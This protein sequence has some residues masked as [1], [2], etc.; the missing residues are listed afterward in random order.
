MENQFVHQISENVHK[1]TV[2]PKQVYRGGQSSLDQFIN[3]ENS[4]ASSK[5]RGYLT[6]FDKSETISEVLEKLVILSILKNQA[7]EQ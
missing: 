5:L 1:I 4:E 6:A 2:D 7:M 3:L